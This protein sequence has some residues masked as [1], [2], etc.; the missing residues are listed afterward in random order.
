MSERFNTE[1]MHN[2]IKCIARL[3]KVTFFSI[4]GN[5]TTFQLIQ[6]FLWAGRNSSNTKAKAKKK[7]EK[8]S[9]FVFNASRGLEYIT[10]EITGGR[11]GGWS[12]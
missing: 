5:N 9:L 12:W 10:V 3:R 8:K 7:K 2:K 11:H 1:F 6:S 4:C